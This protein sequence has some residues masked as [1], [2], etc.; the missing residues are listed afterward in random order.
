MTVAPIAGSRR[1]A[2]DLWY[3]DRRSRAQRA[4]WAETR[5]LRL[6]HR[7]RRSHL[8]VGLRKGPPW[9]LPSERRTVPTLNSTT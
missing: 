9:P 7:L 4:H 1:P 8:A 3:R 2:R 6:F 5:C